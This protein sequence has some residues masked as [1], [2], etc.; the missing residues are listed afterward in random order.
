MNQQFPP[1]WD[2]GRI[3]RVIAHYENQ[4]EDEAVAEDEEAFSREGYATV[5]VPHG[6][7]HEVLLLIQDYED[8]H[9]KK[10]RKR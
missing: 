3:R 10:A 6:I 5:L 8:S 7:L 4:S 1:G 9:V 2:E